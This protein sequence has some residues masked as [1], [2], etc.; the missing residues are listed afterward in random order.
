M[1][2]KQRCVHRSKPCCQT[3]K[4]FDNVFATGGKNKWAYLMHPLSWRVSVMVF[5]TTFY[6]ISIISFSQNLGWRNNLY[7]SV[8]LFLSCFV[9]LVFFRFLFFC[10]FVCSFFVCFVLFSFLFLK[11]YLFCFFNYYFVKSDLPFWNPTTDREVGIKQ[12]S[13]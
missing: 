9:L 1:S 4:H 2:A 5:N 12:L 13:V 3:L 8:M 10:F 6:N 7:L 11:F